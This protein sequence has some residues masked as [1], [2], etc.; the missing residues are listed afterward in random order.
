[1]SPGSQRHHQ[2]PLSHQALEALRAVGLTDGLDEESSARLVSCLRPTPFRFSGGET[3][4]RCGDCADQVWVATR[5]SIRIAGV[6]RDCDADVTVRT[7][8]CVIGEIGPLLG[9]GIRT[10]S[11]TALGAVEGVRFA[12]S[13]MQ[14]IDDPVLEAAF[15]RNMARVLA[16][17]IADGVPDRASDRVA[18]LE[19]STLLKRFVD[20]YALSR[21]YVAELRTAYRSDR[22]VI[23]FSDVVGFSA[24]AASASPDETAEVIRRVMTLQAA[25]IKSAGGQIDK[26]I[27]DGLMAYWVIEGTRPEHEAEAVERAYRAAMQ[28]V[29]GVSAITGPDGSRLGLRIGLEF[30][31][32]ITGNFGS[33]DRYAFTLIGHHVNLAARYEQARNGQDGSSL[34]PV[35]VGEP[36]H[37]RLPEWARL[38]LPHRTQIEVKKTIAPIYTN[39]SSDEEV[40]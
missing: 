38:T 31:E 14:S 15:W 27:G 40:T 37:E 7:S 8:P 13:A 22:V 34:G 11:M 3:I 2:L 39:R 28:A 12:V 18:A 23:W 25:A 20:E 30:G 5:G 36:F 32:A 10:A 6:A 4:C 19:N 24:V 29:S 17:K 26:F 9:N 33:E 35:R 1:M 16:A 21:T